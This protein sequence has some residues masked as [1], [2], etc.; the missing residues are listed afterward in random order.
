MISPCVEDRCGGGKYLVD[1]QRHRGL[2][3]TMVGPFTTSPTVSCYSVELLY[4]IVRV[5]PYR[6]MLS[7]PMYR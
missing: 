2:R 1:P 5:A 4:S 7:A 3:I 6:T